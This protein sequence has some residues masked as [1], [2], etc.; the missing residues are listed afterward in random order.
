MC[1]V[2]D[3][4]KSDYLLWHRRFAH[5]SNQSV[6]RLTNTVVRGLDRNVN[7]NF[8]PC[9]HC[10]KGRQTKLPFSD[11][12]GPRTKAPL[13]LIQ[14]DVC[15]SIK[16]CSLGGGEYFITFTDDFTR[17]STVYIMK[18]KAENRSL[19]QQING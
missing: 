18:S 3:K 8:D 7:V 19:N 5:A 9:E 4:S 6:S 2:A 14:S 16:P 10:C 15:G 12:A 17:Y 13:E 1:N 11:V